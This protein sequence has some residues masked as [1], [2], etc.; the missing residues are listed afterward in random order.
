M[1]A[2]VCDCQQQ[3]VNLRT[4]LGWAT[5]EQATRKPA[6]LCTTGRVAERA[7][8]RLQ[9]TALALDTL[10]IVPAAY[11]ER[12]AANECCILSRGAV[13]NWEAYKQLAVARHVPDIALKE[14]K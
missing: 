10:F 13:G 3:Y 9:G 11:A 2:S 6:T 5:L 14:W 12:G 4:S 8:T 1:P 7:M